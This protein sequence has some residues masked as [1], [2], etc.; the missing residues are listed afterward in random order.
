MLFRSMELSSKPLFTS[1]N[2]SREGQKLHPFG[3]RRSPSSV[4]KFV[5]NEHFAKNK[6]PN[7]NVGELEIHQLTNQQL[8]KEQRKLGPGFKR[9][10]PDMGTKSITSAA[11]VNAK[12]KKKPSTRSS[13]I[14]TDEAQLQEQFE[15]LEKFCFGDTERSG[16]DR[17]H[18][19]RLNSSDLGLSSDLEMS[20]M[21]RMLLTKS[22]YR[23]TSSGSLKPSM[24]DFKSS[25]R[26]TIK[27]PTT[28]TVG[29][30]KKKQ[31]SSNND[32]EEAAPLFTEQQFEDLEAMCFGSPDTTGPDNVSNPIIPI[33][34]HG[35]SSQGQNV[36]G[37]A[38][39]H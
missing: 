22:K 14:A 12:K 31:P 20:T 38:C 27:P 11:A 21:L 25:S 16:N 34:I 33:S 5:S 26:G 32:A 37:P 13:N 4:T 9:R 1:S 17:Q 24:G 6:P 7:N 23:A 8:C 3:N 10:N 36:R 28:T 15:R 29:A 30:D 39:L 2:N 35:K 19:N 18:Q